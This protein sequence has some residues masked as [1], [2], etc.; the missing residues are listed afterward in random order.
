MTERVKKPICIKL[1]INFEHSSAE[2][3]GMIQKDAAMGSWWWAASSQQHA[4]SRIK[5]HAEFFGKTSNHP[6][7]SSLLQ[8]RFS[9]LWLLTF[10]KTKITFEMEEISD[11]WW[12]NTTGQLFAIG[13]TM[14]DPKSYFE[15]DWDVIVLCT[16]IFVSCIFFNKCL[17]FSDYV[18]EY[19]LDRPF[20]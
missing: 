13:E 3:I 18:A 9:T 4:R 2:T 16:M 6:G 20:I 1:C 12:E 14:W 7:D 5:S 8:Y 11:C 19:F 15:G 17:Y 10:P